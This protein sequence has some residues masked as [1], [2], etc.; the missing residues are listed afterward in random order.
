KVLHYYKKIK[1]VELIILG[2]VKVG[3]GDTVIFQ[4]PTT[5]SV[6]EKIT[7]IEKDH[8]SIKKIQTGEKVAIKVKAL[9]REN[10]QVYLIINHFQNRIN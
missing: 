5:G 7:S 3:I 2:N 4:G 1:V 10:D 8:Q 9:I 6:E